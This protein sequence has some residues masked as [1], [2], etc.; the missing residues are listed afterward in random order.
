MR[1][2]RRLLWSLKR[3]GA[4]IG[5]VL[6]GTGVLIAGLLTTVELTP[7]VTEL[8]LATA[9]DDITIIV[10]DVVAEILDSGGLDYEKLVT[11]E[12]NEQGAVTTLIA[13]SANINALRSRV[14]NAVVERFADSDLTRVSVP[15]G[16]LIGG[17]LLSGKGPRIKLDILSVTNV[18]TS[19]RNEFTS[20]GINQTRHRI[21]MDVEVSLEVLLGPDSGTDSVLTEVIVAETVIVGSVPDTYATLQQED[22][23]G[24]EG[25]DRGT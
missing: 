21:I 9:T 25:Q 4:G 18:V 22:M 15:L 24:S 17:T 8:A 3:R 19:F 1:R 5:L 20:A 23:H 2:M 12:R 14:T 11:L 10:N 13:N 6:I 16:N 7:T